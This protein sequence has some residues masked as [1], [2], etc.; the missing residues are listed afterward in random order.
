[1]PHKQINLFCRISAF[2]IIFGLAACASTNTAGPKPGAP[3]MSMSI[4]KSQDASLQTMIAEIAPKFTQGKFQADGVTLNYNLF[5]PEK[6]E[7]GKKYPLV[8]FMADASAT[9]PDVK[10]PLT[11]GYG[12]LVWATPEAQKENPCYVLAPQ[13]SG[14]AVNDAYERTP[15]VSAALQLLKKIVN[16]NQV[17]PLRVYSTGQSMGGMIAMYYDIMSPGIFAASMFVDCHWDTAQFD[18]L[19]E[20]PFIFFYAGE[21]GKAWKMKEPIENAARK[22]GKSYTWSEWSA[23][24]PLTRQD[25]LAQTMLE[26]GQPINII[27]FENGTVLPEG[28]KESEHM[29]S[30]DHAY[31]IAP[32]REWLFKQ[33]LKKSGI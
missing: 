23:R 4:D 14:A 15:E 27:G 26:K 30:F 5:I 7:K 8:M 24:L 12:S 20:T 11:Q 21:N 9:G 25:Q 33:A 22:M 29:Y 17:D 28:V 1:M 10:A 13:F 18:K 16:D 6:L 2:L 19:V 3:G 31:Q 32:A